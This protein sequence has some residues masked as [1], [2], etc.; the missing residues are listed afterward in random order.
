MVGRHERA[1]LIRDLAQCT[2]DGRNIVLVTVGEI[3]AVLA[4]RGQPNPVGQV[5]GDQ[6]PLV[7]HV[8]VEV[9]PQFHAA[10]LAAAVQ[11]VRFGGVARLSP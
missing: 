4:R 6:C 7:E 11:P 1:D 10:D 8:A 2:Q 5:D 3:L 9:E